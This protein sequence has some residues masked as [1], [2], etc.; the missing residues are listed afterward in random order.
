MKYEKPKGQEPLKDKPPMPPSKQ[1]W[2]IV[3]GTPRVLAKG[4]DRRPPK[5]GWTKTV[6][7]IGGYL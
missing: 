2:L 3:E 7:W 6:E 1:S 4:C 5:K